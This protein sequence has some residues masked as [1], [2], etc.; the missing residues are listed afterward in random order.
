MDPE[1]LV[2]WANQTGPHTAALVERILATRRHPQQGY[3]SCLGILRL[4]KAY[5]ADRLEAAC[6]RALAIGGLSYKSIES[7]LKHGLTSKACLILAPPPVRSRDPA[8]RQC[9]RRALL[10]VIPENPPC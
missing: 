1:R 7:I 8:P 4:G 9:A 2:R 5:G 6:Q 3:R 10:P